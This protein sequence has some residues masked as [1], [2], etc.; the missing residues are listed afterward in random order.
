MMLELHRN[1]TK[2]R[3]WGVKFP[4]VPSKVPKREMLA[5]INDSLGLVSPVCLVEKLLFREVCD[6]HL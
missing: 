3:K 6:Q 2:E 5:S 4:E 1:K